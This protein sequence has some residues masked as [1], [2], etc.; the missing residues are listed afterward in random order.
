MVQL[1][2][3]AYDNQVKKLNELKTVKL[4]D[5]IEKVKASRAEGDLSENGGYHAAREAQKKALT[6]IEK[7]E[8]N[9]NNAEIIEGTTDDAVSVG[10]L[11]SAKIGGRDQA[12]VIGTAAMAS[13]FE[14][15]EF[16]VVDEALPLAKATL[17]AVPGDKTDYKTA[18][19]KSI[20]V[21]IIKIES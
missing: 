3:S 1:T 20:S 19:G 8:Y 11:V 12:F 10:K 17:G 21:E 2:K 14:D 6:E 15:K 7:L 13:A 18:S 4:P 5:I 9:I 16:I